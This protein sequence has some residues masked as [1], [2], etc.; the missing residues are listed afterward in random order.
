M[1][2]FKRSEKGIQTKTEEKKDI[3]KRALVQNSYWENC[4]NPRAWPPTFM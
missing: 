3:P 1:S 2:W 4:R